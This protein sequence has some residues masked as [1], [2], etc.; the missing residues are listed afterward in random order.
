MDE[1]LLDS[2]MLSE[3]AKRKDRGVLAHANR[4]LAVRPKLTFSLVTKFEVLRGLKWKAAAIQLAQFNQICADS[5]ILPI[6]DEVVERAAQLWAAA[7]DVGAPCGDADL[8]IAAT[9]LEHNL[10]LCTGNA[11][12]FNWIPGLRLVNWREP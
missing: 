5:I 12:H 9:A 4:Y 3:V 7:M 1:L 10:A 6:D 11:D 8:L 2:D